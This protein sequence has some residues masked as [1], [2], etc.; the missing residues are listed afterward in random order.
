MSTNSSMDN[1]FL[2]MQTVLSVAPIPGVAACAVA[3]QEIYKLVKN[4]ALRQQECQALMVYASAVMKTIFDHHMMNPDAGLQSAITK[5]EIEVAD[6]RND[7]KKWRAY[8][9]GMG[10][11]KNQEIQEC[12]RAHR[13]A[14]D[15]ALNMVGLAHALEQTQWNQ[16]FMEAQAH[17]A[18]LLQ[19]INTRQEEMIEMMQQLQQ[20]LIKQEPQTQ[21]DVNMT[22]PNREVAMKQLFQLRSTRKDSA[23]LPFRELRDEIQKSGQRA[24]HA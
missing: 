7:I 21:Q 11:L 13:V 18:E 3:L 22:G 14:L 8:G 15:T 12:I 2:A 1:F 23:V 9:K 20:L 5:V 19:N 10:Y 4:V 6:M 16:R 17:D 24:M